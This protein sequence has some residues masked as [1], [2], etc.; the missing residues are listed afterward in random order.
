MGHAGSLHKFR[1]MSA[2]DCCR[3]VVPK[4]VQT[5]FVNSWRQREQDMRRFDGFMD[6]KLEQDGDKFVVS[7]RCVTAAQQRVRNNRPGL[8]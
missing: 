1:H 2:V 4:T 6:F 7:S 5:M 3:F 8:N